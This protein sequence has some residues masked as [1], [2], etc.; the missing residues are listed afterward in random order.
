MVNIIDR[1]GDAAAY[2]C[3]EVVDTIET[4][5]KGALIGCEE[6]SQ[7]LYTIYSMDGF[8]K[9]SKAWIANFKFLSKIPC[10]QG[11]FAECLK[12]IEAQKDLYYATLII[13]SLNDF[14]GTR[15]DRGQKSY[16]FTLPKRKVKDRDG[17]EK[18][19]VDLGK[20]FLL[21]GNFFETGKFLQKYKVM[22][23]PTCSKLANSLGS[24][25]LFTFQGQKVTPDDIPILQTAFDKPK[26]IFVVLASVYE[27]YYCFK[28]PKFFEVENLCKFVGST[29]KIILITFGRRY[30]TAYWFAV[31]DVITQ[32][33]SLIGFLWRKYKERTNSLAKPGASSNAARAA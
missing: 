14:I 26:E 10:C 11:V 16:Y 21:F 1:M 29:G 20:I 13:G 15:V 31:A 3:L 32:N 28:K 6:A 23:F 30:H 2:A 12:T 8:E 27:I 18:E 9:W 19:V 22:S 4:I 5:A 33:A 17:K 7:N 24:I 25:K